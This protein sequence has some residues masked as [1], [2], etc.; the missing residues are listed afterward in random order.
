V[1]KQ[2]FRWKMAVI[3]I[4]GAGV[5]LALL[6][7]CS[8]PANAGS[9]NTSTSAV[10]TDSKANPDENFSISVDKS[11]INAGDNFTINILINTKAASRGG[12]CAVTFDPSAMQCNAITEGNFFKDWASANGLST[13]MMP[14]APAIDNSKGTVEPVAIAVMGQSQAEQNGQ[15]GQEA[16]GSGVFYSLQMTAKTGV[17]KQAT[18]KL[19]DVQIAD[20]N[21]DGIKN[22]TS[23]SGIITIGTP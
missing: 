6:A 7:G 4:L 5:L 10:S 16:K 15:S 3:M 19:S 17:N 11:Q 1:K 13:V 21:A 18:I 22:V 8:N 14:S 9:N 20:S 2:M 12:Q 23:S